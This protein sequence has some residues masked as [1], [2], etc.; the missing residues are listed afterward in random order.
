MQQY[1]I[2]LNLIRAAF[3]Q[4]TTIEYDNSLD[5][6]SF[7]TLVK[8]QRLIQLIWPVLDKQED[9]RWKKLAEELKI[10]YNR[11]IH[12]TLFQQNDN[13]T[14]LQEME[15][16][17]EP[18]LPLKGWIMREYY[19]DIFLRNMNDFDVLMRNFERE[20]YW[21]MMKSLGYEL[22][23]ID[24]GQH[25]TYFK[26][27]YTMIELHVSL[28]SYYMQNARPD[29]DRWLK[30]IW[31]RC[32]LQNDKN[33]I[34]RMKPE[35]FYIYHLIHM[36]KHME[37]G[38]CGIRPVI[39]IFVFLKKEEDTLNWTYIN[40]TLREIN[41]LTFER[42]MKKM[43]KECFASE[44]CHLSEEMNKLLIFLLG[45]GL[46][47]SKKVQAAGRMAKS[48]GES[49]TK[50]KLHMI[51]NTVFLPLNEMTIR[52]P[53]LKKHP[54]LLPICWILRVFKMAFEGKIGVF[55]KGS[56]KEAYQ[57]MEEIYRIAGIKQNK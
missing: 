30:E 25:D 29:I 54:F 56:S 32:V 11:S 43:S 47:G 48:E 23:E 46:F 40:Q 57:E 49:D 35:D 36:Y 26:M 38:G 50:K 16:I 31:E 4:T 15:K 22:Y 18:C 52:F 17:G 28:S 19:P 13:E 2:L 41:L 8:Q 27:P 33:Y 6:S 14:F 37:D 1:I 34:Y 9:E 39:D 21:E 20:K 44:K 53:I 3:N 42:S 51:L 24:E 5:I 10:E 7:F 55:I 45:N 12:K